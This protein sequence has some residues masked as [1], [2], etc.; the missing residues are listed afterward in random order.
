MATWPATLPQLPLIQ[1]ASEKPPETTI[2]TNMDAGPAKVRGR[3][4]AGVRPWKMQLVLTTAQVAI[5]DDFY[6]ST[7]SGGANRF[8]WVNPR[9]TSSAEF[10]FTA[11]P[12]YVPLGGGRYTV[13]MQLEQMP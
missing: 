4:S 11:P 5:L 2:R 8:T 12:E 9:T 6:V 1:G 3:F 13:A 7:L 10:R